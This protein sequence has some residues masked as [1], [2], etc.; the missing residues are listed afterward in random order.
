MQGV[1]DKGPNRHVREVAGAF[2]RATRELAFAQVE[3]DQAHKLAWHFPEISRGLPCSEIDHFLHISL[4][5]GPIHM[6]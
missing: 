3:G 2:P 5:T 1:R 6:G 4:I